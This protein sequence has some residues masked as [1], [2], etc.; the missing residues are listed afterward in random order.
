[1]QLKNKIYNFPYSIR[2]ELNSYMTLSFYLGVL[3]GFIGGTVLPYELS[4]YIMGAIPVIFLCAF[5]PLPQTPQHLL[6]KNKIKVCCC[7]KYTVQEKLR[8]IK[9]I[10]S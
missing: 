5:I 1:M 7:N 4:P 8:I 9:I 3:L 10:G 6:R 2:G